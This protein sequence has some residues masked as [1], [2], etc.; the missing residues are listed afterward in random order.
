MVFKYVKYLLLSLIAIIV[1]SAGLI[2][3]TGYSYFWR[4]LSAT[5]L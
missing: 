3:L 5:Y 4:A 1:L 2:Q